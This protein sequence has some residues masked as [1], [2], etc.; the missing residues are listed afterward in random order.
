MDF[1]FKKKKNV[2]LSPV[3]ESIM[4]S[5]LRR[6]RPLKETVGQKERERE[7]KLISLFCHCCCIF[8]LRND[9]LS[10]LELCRR[11]PPASLC[12]GCVG[13]EKKR[14]SHQQAA[15]PPSPPPSPAVAAFPPPQGALSLFFFFFEKRIFCLN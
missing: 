5:Q 12:S 8:L 2:F 14:T 9:M 1:F 7:R 3:R 6:N 11:L 13:V 4:W 15:G 10:L